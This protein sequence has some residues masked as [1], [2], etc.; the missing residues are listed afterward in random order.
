MQ[1]NL[2]IVVSDPSFDRMLSLTIV[3]IITLAGYDIHSQNSRELFTFEGFNEVIKRIGFVFKTL[4]C[5]CVCVC[6]CMYIYI[7]IY[8]HTH[9]CRFLI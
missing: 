1:P 3:H 7:Y 4:V 8:T 2:P 6:V 9:K 5:V